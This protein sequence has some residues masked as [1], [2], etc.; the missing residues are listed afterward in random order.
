MNTPPSVRTSLKQ[1]TSRCP[2]CRRACAGEVVREH[3]K[4]NLHRTCPEHGV[5]SACIAS[6]ERFYWL[7]KGRPENACCGGACCSAD[8]S[9]V[10]TL[11]RNA[12]GRGEESFEI[13]STCVCLIEI[14]H[15]CN[16]ACPTCYANSPEG[17]GAH[18]DA[19]SLG[20]LQRRI[21]D[22]IQRKGKIELLQLS[23]GEPTLHPELFA[24]LEW[25][26]RH[27][28]IDY[29]ILNTNGLRIARDDEFAAG[30]AV[31]A[32]RGGLQLY[33]QFDGPQPEGQALLR[34]ADL[35]ALRETALER[36][37][38]MG[39]VTTLA[40]TVTPENLPFVWDAI[41]FG[42]A[43]PFVHGITFQPMFTSG[44]LPAGSAADMSLRTLPSR[45]NTADILLAAVEKSA[46]MLNYEDLTPLPCGDPNCAVI[47]YLIRTAEG[48]R[49][50]SDYLNFGELQGFLKNK[51]RYSMDD[52]VKCGCE[53]EEL[54]HVLKQ[55]EV[56]IHDTF[57]I[58]VKPFMD[59]W[60]WDQDRIDRCCTHVIRPD[61][62][63][64][65]F[66]RYYSGFPDTV[67][68]P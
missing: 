3:G 15:S 30:L 59:A 45:L 5:F 13:L 66:C 12:A 48:V 62:K 23:G 67:A 29:V 46:G 52:L 41:C 19:V 61:G 35:R 33:L 24:L 11:G 1:T 16:L 2:V 20:N 43:R 36:C 28:K 27:E 26:Q 22:V 14:V 68:A 10:A 38:E 18:L 21:E 44:R 56:G 37:A 8:G 31:A 58:M 64:D 53:V 50:V 54:G 7:A 63:L 4:V 32:K 40:M 25:A 60:T 17:Q 34:G 57:R 9:G 39:L 6:D 42:L 47:G 55:L 65:S 51:L 49:S